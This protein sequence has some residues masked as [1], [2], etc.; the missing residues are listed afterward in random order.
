MPDCIENYYQE[1]GRAGR[2]GAT[3]RAVLLFNERDIEKLE[4]E[5]VLKFPSLDIIRSIYQSLCNFLQVP[6][7]AGLGINYRFDFEQFIRNFKLNANVT[8]NFLKILEQDGH[9]SFREQNFIPPTLVFQTTKKELYEFGK[10]YP[11]YEDL[12]TTLLRVYEGIFDFPAFIS[13]NYISSILKKLE[14]E[15]ISSL[16]EITRFGIISYSPLNQEP[17]IQFLKNR[18]PAQEL[19]IDTKSYEKRKDAAHMRTKAMI[20]YLQHDCC[21]SRTINEYFGEHN[22]PDCGY[23]DVCRSRKNKGSKDNYDLIYS[24]IKIALANQP[25]NAKQLIRE[26]K[27][28]DKEMIWEMIEFLQQ[29]NKLTTS[30]AGTLVWI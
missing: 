18:V 8:Y 7:Y 29:E 11:Q 1:S 12:L 19:T 20:G 10:M 27:D 16:K 24:S 14:H 17:Q 15:I 5:I 3:S 6:S 23:C 21:R 30:E 2:D 26:L 25:L 4:N 9:I 28:Y 22:T 13:E